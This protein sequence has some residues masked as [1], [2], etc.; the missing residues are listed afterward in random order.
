MSSSFNEKETYGV[1]PGHGDLAIS[2]FLDTL[3]NDCDEDDI[4]EE[5]D[6]GEEGS[7]D[8]HAKSEQRWKTSGT[9]GTSA[10]HDLRY[11]NAH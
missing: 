5:D 11:D 6:G 7:N 10:E 4:D 9:I 8:A 1:T 3:A 2:V